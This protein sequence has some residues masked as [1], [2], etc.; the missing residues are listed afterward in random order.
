VLVVDC[1]EE[2]QIRRVTARSGLPRAEVEA[3]MATQASRATRLAAA[4]DVV[5]NS[6]D[7]AAI[8]A[9]VEA[10]HRRYLGL[11]ARRAAEQ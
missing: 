7:P 9:Q 5:D 10:L 11:A 3:I 8:V 2:E 4:D 6:G 1:P